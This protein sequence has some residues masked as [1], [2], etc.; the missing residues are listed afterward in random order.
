MR[1]GIEKALRQKFS[2]LTEASKPLGTAL[3]AAHT[4][5]ETAPALLR[6]Q[7]THEGI[8]RAQLALST[9]F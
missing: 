9:H 1:N 5:D 2:D 8:E 6:T 4:T 3:V 7:Y